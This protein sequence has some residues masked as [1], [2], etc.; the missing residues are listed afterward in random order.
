MES[1]RKIKDATHVISVLTP[2]QYVEIMNDIAQGAANY[3]RVMVNT[4]AK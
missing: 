4:E 2:A 3:V 1:L